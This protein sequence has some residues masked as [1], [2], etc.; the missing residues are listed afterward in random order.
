MPL[1]LDQ[2]LAR[3][4]PPLLALF[5]VAGCAALGSPQA[6]GSEAVPAP[7]AAPAQAVTPPDSA[8]AP[9]PAPRSRTPVEKS[10]VYRLLV[11]EMAGRRGQLDVSAT[12]YLAVARETRDPEVVERAVRI[13][14]AAE[15]DA[16]TLEAARL[17]V[18][19]APESHEARRVLA[20]IY[21]RARR[22]ED[23]VTEMRV[24]FGLLKTTPAQTYSLLVEMLSRERDQELALAAMERFVAGQESD[25]LAQSAL[26]SL[27][28]RGG[29][30]ERAA[31]ILQQVLQSRPDD[32]GTVLLYAQVLQTQ[33]KAREGIDLLAGALARRP[34]ETALRVA[35][36]RLLVADKRYEDAIAE[37]QRVVD[38]HPDNG[39]ARHALALLYLQ[40]EKLDEAERH[41]RSLSVR[42]AR[43]NTARFYL[44]HVAEARGRVDEAISW[45]G[46]VE[47]G[48]N[49][50]D[51]QVRLG[52][53][54]ARQGR[55]D[56][57]RQ[58]LQSVETSNGKDRVR[59]VLVE[60]EL[61]VDAGRLQDALTVHDLALQEFPD[62]ADLL[63]ARAMVGE[64]LDRLDLL[65][66][67]L[68]AILSRDPN[69]V[70]ALNALGFTLADR[71]DRYQEAHDLIVR[72]LA[73]RP[74]D[75][76]IQDS[77]GWVLF[78]LG[79]LPEA[80][81]YLRRAAAQSDD[82]EVAAH[83][84]EVLWASGDEAGAR[85]VWDAVLKREPG[86]KRITELMRR[87]AP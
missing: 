48:D 57:A 3:F 17:W 26:A 83:L 34:G 47:Q 87:L 1:A 32:P 46:Q 76:Y 72:A 60:A 24:L 58:R 59:L 68:R 52:V 79:R 75:Y 82:V 44:G 51:A 64:K 54:L 35:H 23:A 56:E 55:L 45:Y 71:T 61:L 10:L 29:K 73:Q 37:F 28:A 38:A 65:E 80:L 4:S 31:S 13:A 8:L 7:E 74:D 84:G 25:P 70:Q 16:A 50:V 18:E 81:E 6:P 40:T 67:D 5:V 19:V 41:L 62:D 78:R 63:Y 69:H 27:A 49:L 85:Q 36:G 42:G 2:A 12:H 21:L 66:A 11:A 14:A 22:V 86:N 20:G 33:G 30:L 39:D 53:L 9:A 15:D 77:M 43:Q